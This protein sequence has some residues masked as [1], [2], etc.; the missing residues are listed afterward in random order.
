[1]FEWR[2]WGSVDM[3]YMW[4]L[5]ACGVTLLDMHSTGGIHRCRR[6]SVKI[7]VLS[8]NVL[9]LGNRVRDGTTGGWVETPEVPWAL[10]ILYFPREMV[11]VPLVDCTPDDEYGT[12]QRISCRLYLILFEASFYDTL[13][14]N[15]VFLI[16]IVSMFIFVVFFQNW[17]FWNS[18]YNNTQ[19][20]KLGI[21]RNKLTEKF[22]LS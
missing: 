15:C 6:G 5:C 11:W 17:M 18:I 22:M 8:I 7:R 9:R 20:L 3:S 10:V 1:M 16:F 12:A 21:F 13:N 14:Y 4:R 19:K 2:W